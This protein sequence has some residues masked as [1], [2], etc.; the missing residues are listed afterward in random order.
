MLATEVH[1]DKDEVL[2]AAKAAQLARAAKLCF[3]V[4]YGDWNLIFEQMDVSAERAEE[5]IEDLVDLGLLVILERAING[6]VAK[7]IVSDKAEE[8][9]VQLRGGGEE[10]PDP[11]DEPEPV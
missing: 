9:I 11:S 7:Y 4:G 3:D 1:D 5:L 2:D 8:I 6:G 10:P